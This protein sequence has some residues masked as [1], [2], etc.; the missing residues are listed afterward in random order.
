MLVLQCFHLF[1]HTVTNSIDTVVAAATVAHHSFLSFDESDIFPDEP[2]TTTTAST[3][4]CTRITNRTHHEI[5]N[6]API[7]TCCR[8]RCEF[9]FLVFLRLIFP[10]RL[11]TIA[12][13]P[14]DDRRNFSSPEKWFSRIHAWY[15]I[16]SRAR[17]TQLKCT[18]DHVRPIVSTISW[19]VFVHVCNSHRFRFNQ[20]FFR[21]NRAVD[22][23]Q[24]DRGWELFP[25]S[26]ISGGREPVQIRSAV[27]LYAYIH[28]M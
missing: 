10:R 22:R 21:V 20:Q 11:T 4:T 16:W 3:K 24:F 17:T 2:T 26:I 6:S 7:E 15:S 27:W 19:S 28:S 1:E 18:N 8:I 5:K 12:K 23:S 25:F 14:R 9:H 13:R